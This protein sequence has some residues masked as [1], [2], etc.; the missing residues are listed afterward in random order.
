VRQTSTTGIT[1]ISPTAF[2]GGLCQFWFAPVGEVASIPAINPVTQR[3][4][5]Q[6]VLKAGGSW[7]GPNRV[8][9]SS[10]GYTETQ[11]NDTGGS[12]YRQKIDA[13]VI[14][15]AASSRVNLE[16]MALDQYIIVGK[17][18]ATGEYLVF[19]TIDSPMDFD[20]D[21]ANNTAEE[22][23]TK[24]A[25]TGESLHRALSLQIFTP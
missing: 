8:P 17:L 7:R 11:A 25:F 4:S 16:N 20:L 1:N 3:L 19:G 12:F 5:A 10:K 6:P 2:S 14:G 24:I 9:D 22:A 23:K 18:R 15:D 13:V 21:A